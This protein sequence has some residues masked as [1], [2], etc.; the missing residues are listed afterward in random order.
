MIRLLLF[1]VTNLSVISLLCIIAF[2][3]GIQ[4]NNIIYLIISGFLFGFGGAFISLLLSKKIA[5]FSIGSNIIRNPQNKSEIWLLKVLKKQSVQLNIKTPDLTI[6]Q[7]HS[8]NAFATGPRK[9]SSLIAIST[10]LLNKMNKN[11]IKAVIAHEMTHIA[12]GDMITMTLIQGVVNTFVIFLS[13][14]IAYLL[15]NLGPNNNSSESILQK[16][17]AAYLILT[18]FLEIIFGTI[19]S[20]ITMWFSRRREFY[21]DAGSAKIVGVK[22]MIAALEKMQYNPCSL[23]IPKTLATFCINGQKNSI[24][25]LF[26][27]HPPLHVRIQALY[28]R[29]Y[30]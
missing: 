13:R 15:S 12:N 14:G 29:T 8:I 22:N 23:E 7:S 5:L 10:G 17:G 24:V 11:E 27:S 26:M 20:F 1:V 28:N 16:T 6:Y 2:F 4:T 3:T 9:D 30:M 21:A 25:S 18:I 19:A